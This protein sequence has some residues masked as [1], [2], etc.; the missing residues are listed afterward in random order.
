MDLSLAY[1]N[2][3]CSP[4]IYDIRPG[5]E[6]TEAPENKNTKYY[7]IAGNWNPSLTS[8]CPPVR[9]FFGFDWPQFQKEGFSKLG[10]PSD[11]IVP[12]KSVESLNYSTSL[13]HTSNCHTNLLSDP[14]YDL[15]STIF[16]PER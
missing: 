12:I 6:P 1:S 5:A 15:A 14:E 13:G 3:Y 11:G 16:I 2:N 8:N 7:T 10:E 9:N 4:A